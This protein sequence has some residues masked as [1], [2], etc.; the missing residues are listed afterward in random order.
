[1]R[2]SSAQPLQCDF[3]HLKD[4][5]CVIFDQSDN[6]FTRALFPF[7]TAIK[8]ILT[9]LSLNKAV[10]AAHQE[11]RILIVKR[12]TIRNDIHLPALEHGIRFCKE[13]SMELISGARL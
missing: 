5:L 7:V 13:E 1:M 3:I 8:G 12:G 4:N 6:S 2:L 10:K 11:V 9:F